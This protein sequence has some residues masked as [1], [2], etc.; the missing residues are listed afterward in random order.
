M[1]AKLDREVMKHLVQM[2]RELLLRESAEG[3]SFVSP[4]Q[5]PGSAAPQN[6]PALQGRNEGEEFVSPLQGLSDSDLQP[7]ALP[8]AEESRPVGAE[9]PEADFDAEEIFQP[10]RLSLRVF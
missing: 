6:G 9:E 10:R 3:A 4:G 7:R 2:H 5:S 1:S 8:W